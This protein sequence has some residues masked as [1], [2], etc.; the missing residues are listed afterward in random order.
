MRDQE[1]VVLNEVCVDEVRVDEVRVDEPPCGPY[2]SWPITP[3]LCLAWVNLPSTLPRRETRRVGKIGRR[4]RRRR[5]VNH[6]D[7]RRRRGESP[8]FFVLFEVTRRTF[9]LGARGP[10]VDPRQWTDG[11]GKTRGLLG[12]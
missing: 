12:L 2:V 5:R 8:Q 6:F 11:G 10:E 3:S 7:H 1:V 9:H 4:R